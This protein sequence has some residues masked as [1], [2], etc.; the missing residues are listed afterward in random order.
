MAP[1]RSPRPPTVPVFATLSQAGSVWPAKL[2]GRGIRLSA[3]ASRPPALPVHL[4]LI[5]LRPQ[6]PN[7]KWGRVH[8]SKSGDWNNFMFFN[9]THLASGIIYRV[10]SQHFSTQLSTADQNS[11]HLSHNPVG[12]LPSYVPPRRRWTSLWYSTLHCHHC[13]ALKLSA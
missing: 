7:V 6:N 8:H 5:L 12:T 3:F 13:I 2:A 4:Y 10:A 9:F 11:Q 1:S